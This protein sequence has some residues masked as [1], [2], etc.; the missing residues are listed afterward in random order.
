MTRTSNNVL[1]GLPTRMTIEEYTR[2]GELVRHVDLGKS[3]A[4]PRA[5]AQLNSGQ[6]VVAH[7]LMFLQH[8][9]CIV[10]E[11][12]HVI[13]SSGGFVGLSTPCC[14]SVDSHDNIMVVDLSNN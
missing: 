10:D 14:I 11:R 8:R 6:L 12:G 1:V 3:R 9:V 13:K 7:E 5:C 2:E 4:A